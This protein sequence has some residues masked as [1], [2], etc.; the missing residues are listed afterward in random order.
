MERGLRTWERRAVTLAVLAG[1]L[2]IAFWPTPVDTRF[3]GLLLASLRDLHSAGVPPW[4]D[5]MFVEVAANVVLF[6]PIGLL[7]GAATWPSLWWSSGVLGLA[8]SLI[9]E[10]SQYLLLPHRFASADDLAANTLG[11]LC[12]GALTAAW[13]TLARRRGARRLH[14]DDRSGL[15]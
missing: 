6:V 14:R 5:Y 2:V 13:K 1:M 8:L 3:D 7:I 9:I 15:G 10:F 12:G 4:I 11:A